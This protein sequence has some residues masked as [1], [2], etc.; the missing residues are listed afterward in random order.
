MKL[1][2]S[3][4]GIAGKKGSGK[5]TVAGFIQERYKERI[6][7][8]WIDP[9][10]YQAEIK[11]YHFADPLRQCAAIAFGI[12][13]DWFYREELKEVNINLWDL[14]P[15]KILQIL[16][17]ECFREQFREDFW[18]FRAGIELAKPDYLLAITAIPDVRYENEASFI[19]EREGIILHVKRQRKEE[20]AK[21]LH[22]SE[23]GIKEL[24]E[25]W[26]VSSPDGVDNLK[27]RTVN[28]LDYLFNKK[29]GE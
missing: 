7:S 1:K 22:R 20:Q 23:A 19:R 28:F 24:D 21:D 26:V 16:G 3:L 15:R 13:Q 11:I 18:V 29:E 5:D 8:G 27:E 17:T 10:M 12:G 25:D 6:N 9:D 4:I 14:T 2:H